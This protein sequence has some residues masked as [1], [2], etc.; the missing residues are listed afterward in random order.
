MP[1]FAIVDTAGQQDNKR[2]R[3]FCA[4]IAA[5]EIVV[6]DEAC[7]HLDHLSDLDLRDVWWVT[8]AKDNMKFRVLK[9]HTKGHEN[10]IK[11]QLI[12]LQGKH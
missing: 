2:A 1:S 10:I 5:G 12:V 8:R 4:T 9:N 3:E 7:V 11:D 6:F